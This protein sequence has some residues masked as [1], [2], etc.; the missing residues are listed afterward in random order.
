M[1]T[2]FMRVP[3]IWA[4]TMAERATD[5]TDRANGSINAARKDLTAQPPQRLARVPRR[6]S[7]GKYLYTSFV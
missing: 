5:S 1:D 2:G 6:P 3:R 4:F 7:D